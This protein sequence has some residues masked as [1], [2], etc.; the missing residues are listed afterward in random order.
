MRFKTTYLLKLTL[1]G[2]A[3]RLAKRFLNQGDEKLCIF[4][5]HDFTVLEIAFHPYYKHQGGNGN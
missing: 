5:M 1:F 4:V 2:T 3:N